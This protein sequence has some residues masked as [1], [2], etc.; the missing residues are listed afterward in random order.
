M[1]ILNILLRNRLDAGVT[2]T[3]SF[4]VP[5]S[6]ETIRIFLDPNATDWNNPSLAGSLDLL[7]SSDGGNTWNHL[8]GMVFA[9]ASFDKDGNPPSVT[10][11][12]N[13]NSTFDRIKAR[14]ALN[15]NIRIGLVAEVL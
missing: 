13:E 15:D 10:F 14:I 4:I 1:T 5:P 8:V 2:E 7:G 12:Q 11:I 6:R 3:P 9:G